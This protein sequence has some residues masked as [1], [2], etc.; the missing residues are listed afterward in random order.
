ME[1]VTQK[2]QIN[3]LRKDTVVKY[4]PQYLL[5]HLDRDQFMSELSLIRFQYFNQ[6][7]KEFNLNS[8]NSIL[9]KGDWHPRGATVYLKEKSFFVKPKP[10]ETEIFI[11]KILDSINNIQETRISY[12]KTNKKGKFQIQ[13]EIQKK[14]NINS[15][16]FGQLIAL[17]I[18]LGIFDL[19]LENVIPK[20]GKASL[21]DFDCAFWTDNQNFD[22]EQRLQNSGLLYTSEKQ[23]HNSLF[24]HLNPININEI[25]NSF[26]EL[27][28]IFKDHY[29]EIFNDLK[30]INNVFFRRV[31]LDTYLY[32]DFL[33]NK[34]LFGWN[35]DKTK[36]R[37]LSLRSE[38]KKVNPNLINYE[39]K[40][41]QNW[42]IPHFVIKKNEIFGLEKE[43]IPIYSKTQNLSDNIR[44]LHTK[45]KSEEKQIKNTTR[46][47]IYNYLQQRV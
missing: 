31:Y 28:N 9:V 19:H 34:F 24:F 23:L 7:K 25:N 30:S 1:P 43:L 6:L 33:K 21:I 36:D 26:V 39:L 5:N 18:W 37:W 20:N 16:T 45:L 10:P 40:C 38:N 17:S 14:G 2:Y 4:I 46:K 15:R 35:S 41:L 12:P 27:Y 8:I 32:S 22:I 29:E 3:D 13:E 42:T 47:F 11:S 44:I